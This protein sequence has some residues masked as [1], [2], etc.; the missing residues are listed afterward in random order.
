MNDAKVLIT[1]TYPVA[2]WVNHPLIDGAGHFEA[3]ERIVC[4]H[5]EIA[6]KL[7]DEFFLEL[8]QLLLKYTK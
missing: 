8:N 4:L 7:P 6:E 3:D 1:R 2:K 5:I